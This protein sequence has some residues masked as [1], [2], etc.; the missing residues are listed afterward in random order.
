MATIWDAGAYAV[1]NNTKENM[2]F[3]DCGL[4]HGVWAMTAVPVIAPGHHA[5][6][7]FS[8]TS[9]SDALV[10]PQGYLTYTLPNGAA[11]KITFDVPYMLDHEPWVRTHLTGANSELYRTEIDVQWNA[12]NG[13]AGKRAEATIA[14]S[15]IS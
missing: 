4:T 11:L 14:L 1:F 6:P 9:H 5:F 8:A 3:T 12:S 15:P 7:A 13:G 10:G 2:H